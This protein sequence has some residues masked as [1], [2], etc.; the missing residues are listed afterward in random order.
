M[1]TMTSNNG[2]PNGTGNTLSAAA[3]TQETVP[4]APPA[5][6]TPSNARLSIGFMNK[7]TDGELIVDSERIFGATY[8][9]PV[10][11]SA[12]PKA[13]EFTAARNTYI[14]A[15]NAAQDSI[16]A[17]STRRTQRANFIALLRKL[18]H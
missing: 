10:F 16:I 17:R 8:G 4:T 7:D 9:N 1:E 15:V 14:A 6:P 2:A 18:A 13:A 12:E 5:A 3:S 11:A